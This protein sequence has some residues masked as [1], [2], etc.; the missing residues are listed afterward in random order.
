VKNIV[1][2]SMIVPTVYGPVIV[3]RY[4]I[5][6]TT[7]LIKE[8]KAFNHSEIIALCEILRRI[9]LSSS[10][11]DCGANFGLYSLAF[12]KVMEDAGGKVYA[13]EGQ[14]ILANMVQ[15]TVALNGLENMYV[16]NR[17]VGNDTKLIPIPRFDYNLECNFGSIEFGPSQTEQLSQPRAE[18]T[19]PDMVELVKLDD[20]NIKR[21]AL[22]KLDI[23]GM[24]LDALKGAKNLISRDLPILFIEWT[25]SDREAILNFCKELK[26]SVYN[27]GM[28]FLA[29]Q[30]RDAEKLTDLDIGR[31]SGKL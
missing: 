25:K 30:Q 28:D 14:R 23:E 4:D 19:K 26:Y 7:H 22:I 12:A 9:G 18:T 29:I 2:Y 20:Q 15:G 3:N 5:N 16:Y 27:W 6:Q 17:A 21:V 10:V 8:G 31:G 1:P 24:E 13:F 11:I